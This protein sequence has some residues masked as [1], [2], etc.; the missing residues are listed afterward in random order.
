[1]LN[2]LRKDRKIDLNMGQSETKSSP[3]SRVSS[4]ESKTNLKTGEPYF[5]Q[6][7]RKDKAIL[8]P[9]RNSKS[10]DFTDMVDK[11][12]EKVKRNGKKCVATEINPDRS[13]STDE[14]TT[15]TVTSAVENIPPN[16]RTDKNYSKNSAMLNR[17]V[18]KYT[19][20]SGFFLAGLDDDNNTKADD[21]N[22]DFNPSAINGQGST[23]KS[24][25]WCPPSSVFEDNESNSFVNGGIND[26]LNDPI[27]PSK[28]PTAYMQ[29]CEV[30]MMNILLMILH[31]NLL[32]HNL[33]FL[34]LLS[35]FINY[36]YSI[37]V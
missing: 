4:P 27:P 23:L 19:D 30:K 31:I 33:T 15:I 11:S 22:G 16:I 35:R 9:L 25:S 37:I 32:L 20:L 17:K 8:S 12:V 18:S 26:Y 7:S 6:Y 1:M 2:K 10:L 5:S 24:G 28:S 34:T 14:R 3:T 13:H 21:K 29:V 36:L